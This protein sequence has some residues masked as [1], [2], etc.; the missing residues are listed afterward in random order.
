MREQKRDLFVFDFAILS[1]CLCLFFNVLRIRTVKN[2]CAWLNHSDGEG[3]KFFMELISR[4]GDM[5]ALWFNGHF[6]LSHN[7]YDSISVVGETVFVQTGVIGS[8]HRYKIFEILV[9]IDIFFC[10][11]K[12]TFCLF[13][14]RASLF[15]TISSEAI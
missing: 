6:H 12:G 13:V 1:L 7:Y 10:K 5:I 4:K 9:L 3:L 8:C 2:R 11:E 14:L 15:V